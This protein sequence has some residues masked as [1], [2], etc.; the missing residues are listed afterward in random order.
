VSTDTLITATVPGVLV[1][2]N[3][4]FTHRL[5][6]AVSDARSDI[7][8]TRR[9]LLAPRKIVFDANGKPAGTILDLRSDAPSWEA[10]LREAPVLEVGRRLD[11]DP[12]EAAPP[13]A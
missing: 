5:R 2:F 4:W 8:D 9:A 3:T 1:M 10:F 7:A 12:P 13:P 6:R 11:D